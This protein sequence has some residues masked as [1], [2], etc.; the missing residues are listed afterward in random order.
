M[1]LLEDIVTFSG[2]RYWP[3][4]AFSQEGTLVYS[5]SRQPQRTL[6][7]VDRKGA[8]E[9]VPLTP[10]G[11]EEV[12]ISPDGE[13]LAAITVDK[14][15]KKTLM[16]GD[17]ARGTL[18]RSGAEGSLQGLAWTPDG[19]RVAF[20]FRPGKGANNAFW[21][22]ADGSTPP[23]RLTGETAIQQQ[24]PSSFSPDGSVVLVDAVNFTSSSASSTGWDMFILPLSGGRTFRPFLQTKVNEGNGVFSPDGR[25]IAYVSN[26]SG[27]NEVFV[28]PYPGPG[29]KWQISTEG[30]DEPVWPRNGR[31]LFYR[32]GDSKMMVVEVET[33]PTFRPGRPRTLFEGRFLLWDVNTYDV[34]RDGT[35]F[36]MIK[37][38]PAE[39]GPTQV[40]VVLNWFEDVKRRVPGA[41]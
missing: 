30:G 16:F 18:S 23:E 21:Q 11:Y 32:Q 7:W 38:D 2:F 24:H 12:A 15:E 4:Y 8:T 19:K 13:R 27:R 33:K 14:H 6:V 17:F 5:V 41:K 31:E 1:P 36:L 40:K 25:W 34:A 22:A 39:S 28:R 26:E 35:R 37:E 29:G 10:A 20:G 9:R 3:E